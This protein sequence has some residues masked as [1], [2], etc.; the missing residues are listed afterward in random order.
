MNA[1]ER[2]CKLPF[3]VLAGNGYKGR[4]RTSMD[5]GE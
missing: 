3:K 5:I 4:A 1:V 2:T